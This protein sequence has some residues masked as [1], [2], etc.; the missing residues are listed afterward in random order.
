MNN[1]FDGNSYID[2]REIEDYIEE[3]ESSIEEVET[4]IE[5][6]ETEIDD[7]LDDE[8]DG[9]IEEVDRLEKNRE[10][11]KDSI[12]YELKELEE[13]REIR[14]EVPGWYGGNTLIIDD[15][16][17]AYVEEMLKDIGYITRDFPWWIEIDWEKTAENV[18]VD[19]STVE[20]KGH[21][22]Y[23]RSC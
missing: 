4:Q 6:L 9:N 18:A 3:L 7:L 23:Y 17:V 1:P 10:V 11:L 14:E 2:T 5:D 8:E 16:W 15:E 12:S 20:Y 19:Y 22:Y 21:T 13:L